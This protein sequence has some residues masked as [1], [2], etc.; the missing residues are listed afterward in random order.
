MKAG[1]KP[2]RTDGGK[3]LSTPGRLGEELELVPILEGWT[4]L[5]YGWN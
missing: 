2:Y 1:P 5:K 3:A 4:E